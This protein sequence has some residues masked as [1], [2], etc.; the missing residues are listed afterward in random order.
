MTYPVI[1]AAPLLIAAILMAVRFV[2]CTQNFDQFDHNNP[3]TVTRCR[4]LTV[5]SVSGN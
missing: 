4:A 5:W 3:H 1:I 2:G